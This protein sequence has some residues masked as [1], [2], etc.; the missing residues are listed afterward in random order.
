MTSEPPASSDEQATGALP[1]PVTD[2]VTDP[3]IDRV[4]DP[5]IDRVI[6]GRPRDIGGFPVRRAL[7]AIGHRTVGPNATRKPE[8][9]PAAGQNTAT[10][11]AL[12]SKARLSCAARK[13]TT[14]T[15]IETAHGGH[16]RCERTGRASPVTSSTLIVL[17]R[18]AHAIQLE[19]SYL[20]LSLITRPLSIQCLS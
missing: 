3:V 6:E 19:L 9:T 2:R 17:T 20:L 18:L 12:S 8:A 16:V 14:A 7:P 13:K 5:V 15:E 11:S 1:D 10:P 4:P